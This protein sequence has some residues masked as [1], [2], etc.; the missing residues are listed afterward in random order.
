MPAR[1]D[2]NALQAGSFILVTVILIIAIV[3]GIKGVG[4]FVAPAQHRT[5]RFKMSDDIGGLGPGDDVRIGGAKVGVVRDVTIVPGDGSDT[6][7]SF[8]EVAFSIPEQ[9][10]LRNGTKVTVQSTLT[11][12]S[13][14]NFSGLGVGDPLKPDAVIQGAPSGLTSFLA[15]AGELGPKLNNLVQHVDSKIDPIVGQ[16]D[17]IA[18]KGSDALSALSSLLGDTHSDVRATVASLNAIA[19]KVREK[20]PAILE[21]LQAVL[22]Q[23]NT[24][25]ARAN[26]ALVDVKTVAAHTRDITGSVREMLIGN[27]GKIEEMIASLRTTSENLKGASAEIRRSPWRLL[28]HP[29]A[30]EMANLNLYDSARQFADGANN[31]SDAATALRDEI[32][33]APGNKE[34]LEAMTKKL[35]QSFEHFNEVEQQLWLRVKE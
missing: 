28:Y 4:R 35:D 24:A 29:S 33:A 22:D 30:G 32:K 13:V 16:Y 6:S 21:R 23:V 9:Y 34:Q 11:G 17:A 10:V 8:I 18:G 12:L 19:A 14:L 31:L 15:S 20:L 25:T 27:R 3:V 1:T 26:D 7:K 5:V 2:R